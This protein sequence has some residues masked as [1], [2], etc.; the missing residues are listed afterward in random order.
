M[1]AVNMTPLDLDTLYM[2][3]EFQVQHYHP[4]RQLHDYAIESLG[5]CMHL[6]ATP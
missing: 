5:S 4:K 6:Q 3:S 2:M 1:D